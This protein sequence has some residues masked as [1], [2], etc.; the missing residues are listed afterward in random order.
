MPGDAYRAYKDTQVTTASPGE[1]LLLL[2]D[3]AIR[4][5]NQAVQRLNEGKAEEAHR[6]LLR[7]QDIVAEMSASLDFDQELAHSLYQLYSYMFGRLVEANVKKDPKP[8]SEVVELLR[9]LR[10]A[11]E[12]A[13]KKA[14]SITSG[15]AAGAA[16]GIS[17]AV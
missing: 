2:Y 11:W 16:R 3:G 10:E 15:E 4:F 5:G 6:L 14:E 8:V 13:V 7:T 1:L 9:S 17:S 12:V